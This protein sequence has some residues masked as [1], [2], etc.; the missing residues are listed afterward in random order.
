M[1]DQ[2]WSH[3]S[4]DE[5]KCRGSGECQMDNKFMHRLVQLRKAY[6]KPLHITS[7]YRSKK[8]NKAIGGSVNSPHLTG[9]AVDIFIEKTEAYWLVGLAIEVGM[10]GIG[11]HQKGEGRFLHLDDLERDRHRVRPTIWSY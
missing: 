6:N 9:N 8:Y 7:G 11:L 5:L 10:T 2:E 3:F 4:H 1:C